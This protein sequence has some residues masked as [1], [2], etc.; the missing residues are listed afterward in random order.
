LLDIRFI[1]NNIDLVREG[2]ERKGDHADI[3]KIIALDE[4]R[5]MI[6]KEVEGL[7]EERNRSSREIGERR[8]RGEDVTGLMADMKAL[9]GRI[10][11]LEKS[12]DK[13]ESQLNAR[14]LEVPNVPHPS[15]PVGRSD[16]DNVEVRRWGE[17]R[18]FPFEPR[19]H[20]EIGAKL[21]IIDIERGAKITGSG[22]IHYRG[23]GALLERALINFMID[24]HVHNH[25]FMEVMVPYVV[26]R[27]SMTVTGQIP[28]LEGDMYGLPGDDAFLIPTAEVPVTNI[29]RGEILK[30]KDLPIY[31][32]AY[33]PCFRREAGA[34]GKDTRG[35]IRVHQFDKVELVKYVEPGS[36]YDELESLVA[37]AEDVLKQLGLHYR[38]VLL[39][40][41]DLSFAASKCYDLEVW[42]PGVGKYLEVSSCSNFEDFQARRGGIRYRPGPGEKPILVHTLNG[43]GLALPRTFI[44][45]LEKYQ[46][47]DGSVIVPEALR[48]YMNGLERIEGA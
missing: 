5:R 43:S 4:D 44:A 13:A 18:D 47:E 31:Y 37:A 8:K 30:A 24:L 19:P 23:N 25:G 26:N 21:G 29:H 12:L 33:S 9:S 1:R 45:L 2:A 10:R 3:L 27:T 42:A 7:R 46:Q 39:S 36:S 22:F 17:R 38:V 48:P 20:W 34:H 11:K 6:L 41:G 32:V 14:L 35:L 15:V 40:T 28:K 16:A